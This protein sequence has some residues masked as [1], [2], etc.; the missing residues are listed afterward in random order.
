[1]FKG[2]IFILT[3]SIEE[4][5]LHV[6]QKDC[7]PILDWQRIEKILKEAGYS[8]EFTDKGIIENYGAIIQ[9]RKNGTKQMWLGEGESRQMAMTKA[10]LAFGKQNNNKIQENETKN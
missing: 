3:E 6:P 5:A 4:A 7:I 8:L 2:W 10:L 9:D 1:M